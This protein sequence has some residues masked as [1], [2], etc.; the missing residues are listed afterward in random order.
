[1]HGHRERIN[2]IMISHDCQWFVSASQDKTL[3]LWELPSGKTIGEPFAGHSRAVDC[4]AISSDSRLVV[5]GS[6]DRTISV[7][8]IEGKA[9]VK[10]L[11]HDSFVVSVYVSPDNQQIISMD[12]QDRIYL[13]SV[14]TGELIEST[15]GALDKAHLI[16]KARNEWNV[17]KEGGAEN[18]YEKPRVTVVGQEVYICRSIRNG[19]VFEKVGQFDARVEDW[20]VDANGILWVCFLVGKLARLAMVT[21]RSLGLEIRNNG[22][23]YQ[24]I[25]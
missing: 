12:W 5:S 9:V 24:K 11:Q 23:S 20:G 4:V 16:W 2:A 8:D 19:K 6:M 7:W 21:G 15:T 1:M 14:S 25:Q 3:R 17:E 13:W 18:D 22:D 10:P